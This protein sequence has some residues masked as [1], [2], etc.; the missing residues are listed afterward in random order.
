MNSV[1]VFRN[2]RKRASR[3]GPASRSGR[4]R[5]IAALLAAVALAAC[6]GKAGPPVVLITLDTTRA[7]ALGCLGAGSPSSTPALDRLASQGILFERAYTVAPQTQ[8][9]HASMLTGLYPPRHGLR[10]NG[11]E[12]LADSASTL[13]EVARERGY[14]TAAFL[15][16]SVLDRAAGLAR[17]FDVYDC[18]SGEGLDGLAGRAVVERGIRW[19][20]RAGRDSRPIFLW[21]HLFDPHFPYSAA[22]VGMEEGSREAY[23][24][25]VA[26]MDGAVALLVEALEDAALLEQ[27]VV[28]VVGDHGESLGEHGE[29]T[30]GAFCYDATLRV[31]MILRLPGGRRS[32]ERSRATV[33]V[34]DVFSTL[35]RAM[36]ERLPQD[37]AGLDLA[38]ADPP[39]E[40]GVYFESILGYHNYG[41]S[42]IAGWI[43]GAGKYIHTSRPEFFRLDADPEEAHDRSP[44]IADLERYLAGV[45]GV[46][47]T[48]ASR[49]GAAA[50]SDRTIVAGL[51]ALGYA[52]G[53]A[54]PDL[55]PL[56]EWS[57]LPVPATRVHERAATL[58][59]SALV[60][61]GRF[62][63]ARPR[64]EALVRANRRNLQAVEE[65]AE[66]YLQLGEPD[67]AIEQLERLLSHRPRDGDA[68]RRLGVCLIERGETERGLEQL[69]RSLD[70]LDRAPD[71]F[72]SFVQQCRVAQREDLVQEHSRRFR[73]SLAGQPGGAGTSPDARL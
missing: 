9:A 35:A 23:L 21:V 2:P 52:G 10:Q 64:L 71:W 48:S 30:H 22:R 60:R 15:G 7:D 37:S 70:L 26:E 42:P 73:L 50:A 16:S 34:V 36:G 62:D 40:R 41:W 33:S 38:D 57:G 17:G 11:G 4:G 1:E 68:A 27:A 24:A 67:F 6:G 44:E 31:P 13:A 66:V 49:A 65:L 56:A 28:L 43:D 29:Q 19:L 20:E 18:P 39:N 5:R 55:P 32:G 61:H 63:V 69:S 3:T 51:Q 59:A 54:S 46:I 8:P 45:A 58:E 47:T 53:S 25:D 14:Q 12:R 72:P